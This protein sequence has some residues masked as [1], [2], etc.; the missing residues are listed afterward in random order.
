LSST[1]FSWSTALWPQ[2]EVIFSKVEGCGARSPKGTRQNSRQATE[3]ET[4]SQSA[5]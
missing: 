4:S 1:S 3:P 5:S 2:R